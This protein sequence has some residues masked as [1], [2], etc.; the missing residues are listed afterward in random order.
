M[1][2][3]ERSPDKSVMRFNIQVLRFESKI[4]TV[5]FLLEPAQFPQ[6]NH[7]FSLILQHTVPLLGAFLAQRR[8]F[9]IALRWQKRLQDSVWKYIEIYISDI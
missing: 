5:K 8:H 3:N 9:S 1:V 7:V 4:V 2:T 6:M